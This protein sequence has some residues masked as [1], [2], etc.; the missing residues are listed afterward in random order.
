[1][2]KIFYSI[3]I[4]I[5]IAIT[6]SSCKSE[7]EKELVGYGKITEKNRNGSGEET[8]TVTEFIY[9]DDGTVKTKTQYGTYISIPIKEHY[10]YD[11]NGYMVVE[12]AEK[13]GEFVNIS[14]K[15]FDKSGKLIYS[16]TRYSGGRERSREENTYDEKGNVIVK[17]KVENN[18]GTIEEFTFDEK[19]NMTSRI[20]YDLNGKKLNEDIIEY[21]YDEKGNL[22]KK[23]KNGVL[24]EEY[25]YDEKGNLLKTYENGFLTE[26]TYDEKGNL[27]KTKI[28]GSLTE[29]FYDENNRKTL[30]KRDT[31]KVEFFYD[32]RG[33]L[34]RQNEYGVVYDS[35]KRYTLGTSK[36]FFYDEAD[37]LVTT[38]TYR[39]GELKY[40]NTHLQYE[41]GGYKE[42]YISYEA[43]GTLSISEDELIY[44]NPVYISK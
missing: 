12:Q 39:G 23:N 15:R 42:I 2:K 20:T 13:D 21:T 26:Y 7:P 28:N 31:N 37:N 36:E 38:K 18:K 22:L 17:K 1:M 25:A 27:L 33:N 40:E 8:V 4:V 3:L 44:E 43:D 14:E 9:N 29:Y 5:V 32:N 6:L 16:V 24:T 41:N 35:K 19:N 30:E 34:I 11:E 10:L